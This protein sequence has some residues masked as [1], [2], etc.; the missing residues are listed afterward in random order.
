MTKEKPRIEMYFHCKE[1]GTGRLSVG[2]TDEGVQVF[3]EE[4]ELNVADLDFMGKKIRFF[5]EKAKKK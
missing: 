4:C 1:C 3:C 2:W 5:Q